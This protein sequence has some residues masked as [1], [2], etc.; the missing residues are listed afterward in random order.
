LLLLFAINARVRV[1]QGLGP[2]PELRNIAA[3]KLS[4]H[5][6]QYGY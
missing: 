5:C 4:H 3:M 1:L 2:Q 6:D